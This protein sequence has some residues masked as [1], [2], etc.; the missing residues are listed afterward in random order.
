MRNW[1]VLIHHVSNTFIFVTKPICISHTFKTKYYILMVG[2]FDDGGAGSNSKFEGYN[3]IR[4]SHVNV[5]NSSIS[6][7][8]D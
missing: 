4:K 2:S 6:Y 7:G 8:I 3:L 1:N 5:T